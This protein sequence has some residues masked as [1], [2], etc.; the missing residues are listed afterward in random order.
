MY[1]QS[2]TEIDETQILQIL[3]SPL[4]FT[5]FLSSIGEL[6]SST[7]TKQTFNE[8]LFTGLLISTTHLQIHSPSSSYPLMVAML[9]FQTS[10]P[11]KQEGMVLD[12]ISQ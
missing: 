2:C 11:F 1:L 7:E 6:D 8:P 10:T 9:T 4:I 3:K 5:Q 12:C